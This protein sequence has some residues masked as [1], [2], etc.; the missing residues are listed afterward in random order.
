MRGLS[1]TPDSYFDK[2]AG[3]KVK[4][5]PF[6]PET[7]IKGLEYAK[8]LKKMLDEDQ[9]SV[10][11]KGSTLFEI[12]GKGEIEVGVYPTADKWQRIIDLLTEMYGEPGNAEENYARFNDMAGGNEVE[13]IV[14]KGY[15]AILDQK[16]TEFLMGHREML[17]EY[18][19][20]KYDNC[21]SKKDYMI[22]KAKFFRRVIEMIPV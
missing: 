2:F 10:E 11:L 8:R 17:V 21:Q 15:E 20:L 14:M 16:L 4:L 1:Q 7:K 13:I 5:I 3:K 19:Q 6:N 18:E 22:A 12:A 9:V